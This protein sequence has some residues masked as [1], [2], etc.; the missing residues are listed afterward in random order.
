MTLLRWIGA[1]E[2][3]TLSALYPKNFGMA[4]GFCHAA[5]L[6]GQAG[7]E[8]QLNELETQVFVAVLAATMPTIEQTV[9]DAKDY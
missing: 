3:T 5:Y 7:K 2:Y 8:S 9:A 6:G 1:N 4:I